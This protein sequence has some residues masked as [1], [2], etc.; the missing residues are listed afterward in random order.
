MNVWQGAVRLL[1]QRRLWHLLLLL[2]HDTT[3]LWACRL[4]CSTS[5]QGCLAGQCRWP[6]LLLLSDTSS[7]AAVEGSGGLAPFLLLKHSQTI[8]RLPGQLS[9]VTQRLLL[10]W[11]LHCRPIACRCLSR[12]CLQLWLPWQVPR[13]TGSMLCCGYWRRCCWASLLQRLPVLLGVACCATASRRRRDAGACLS[14][15]TRAASG[16]SEGAL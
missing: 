5:S 2:L 15:W 3:P 11:C 9:L 8:I 1:Q 7:V 13:S 10:A 4:G 14:A 16:L 12:T 6:R